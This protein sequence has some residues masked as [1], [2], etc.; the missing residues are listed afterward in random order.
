MV[1]F[2]LMKIHLKQDLNF[3]TIKKV[4]ANWKQVVQHEIYSR[5]NQLFHRTTTVNKIR[6]T[7]TWFKIS[8]RLQTETKLT[9]SCNKYT[10]KPNN[11]LIQLSRSDTRKKQWLLNLKGNQ[12]KRTTIFQY[13]HKRRRK[14]EWFIKK[15][16]VPQ[17]RLKKVSLLI[18]LSILFTICR[19]SSLIANL[20]N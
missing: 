19:L 15:V 14:P 4:L 5:F 11:D 17:V 20:A 13:K 1:E 10:E 8:A 7:H 12:S 18:S 2:L 9:R 6:K 16:K 3:I